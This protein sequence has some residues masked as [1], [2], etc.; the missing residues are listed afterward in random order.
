MSARLPAKF[1]PPRPR[2]AIERPRLHRLLDAAAPAGGIW[3]Q[4]E[5][6]AG[7]S[8]LA[9]AWANERGL[10]L[11]WFRVD[12]TDL[13]LRSAF[14]SLAQLLASLSRKRLPPAITRAPPLGD[15]AAHTVSSALSMPMPGR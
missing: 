9:A 12:S 8:T 2:Q 15:D 10:P 3:L 5:A 7:K 6:G 11:A 14:A 13:D 4:A 1:L